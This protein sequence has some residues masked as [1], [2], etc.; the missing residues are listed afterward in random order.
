MIESCAKFLKGVPFSTASAQ[1]N[2]I[3]VTVLIFGHIT[4]LPLLLCE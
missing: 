3:S 4:K 2:L 1:Y